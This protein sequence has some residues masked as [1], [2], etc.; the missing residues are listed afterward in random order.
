MEEADV[1]YIST[2]FKSKSV[3]YF[4]FEDLFVVAVKKSFL[5]SSSSLPSS[6]VSAASSS[7]SSQSSSSAKYRLLFYVPLSEALVQHVG[8]EGQKKKKKERETE[9]SL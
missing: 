7:S 2:K 3:H 5:S 6:V 9:R 8:V 1:V 4:L